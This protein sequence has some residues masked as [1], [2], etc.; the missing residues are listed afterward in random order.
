MRTTLWPYG[1]VRS[2][3]ERI[4]R[5]D[6][7]AVRTCLAGNDGAPCGQAARRLAPFT[8]SH[9]V[10]RRSTPHHAG[11][12]DVP[13]LSSAQLDHCPYLRR[14]LLSELDVFEARSTVE[15]LTFHHGD[16]IDLFD[17]LT[18]RLS[19]QY[20]QMPRAEL[21]TSTELLSALLALSSE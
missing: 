17:P 6:V 3:A 14:G 4:L 16:D 2:D 9:A 19:S 7:S 5:S 11:S 1:K 12:S 21:L 13:D 10:P 18:A 15:G 20:A 8:P